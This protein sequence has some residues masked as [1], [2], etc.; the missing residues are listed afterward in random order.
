MVWVVI[1]LGVAGVALI[2]S[3]VFVPGGVLGTLGLLALIA[4]IVLAIMNFSTGGIVAT[5]LLIPVAGVVA[6][7]VAF[8]LL[9]RTRLGQSVFLQSTQKGVSVLSGSGEALRQLIGKHG[10]ALSY[11]RPAGVA[12]IDGDRVDVVTEGE[13]VEAGTPIVV[14]EI[15]GNHLVVRPVE[16]QSQSEGE[17]GTS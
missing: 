3:E 7:L 10:V 1:L 16:E 9:R 13:Y 12:D 17:R 2:I 8:R 14:L 4:G 6:W 11:L 5:V 15:E